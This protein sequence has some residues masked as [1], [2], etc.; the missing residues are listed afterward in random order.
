MVV[1]VMFGKNQ[2]ITVVVYHVDSFY[3]RLKS[4]GQLWEKKSVASDNKASDSSD[5]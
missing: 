4:E 1:I 5:N 3:H 2:N